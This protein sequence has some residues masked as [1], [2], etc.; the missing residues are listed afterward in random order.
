MKYIIKEIKDSL[1]SFDFWK[2]E[3][4]YKEDIKDVDIE[5]AQKYSKDLIEMW[6]D[7]NEEKL[8]NKE[9]LLDAI[10]VGDITVRDIVKDDDNSLTPYEEFLYKKYKEKYGNDDE[11]LEEKAEKLGTVISRIRVRHLHA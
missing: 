8:Y 10:Y 6:N 4:D 7:S 2:S 9:D 3:S 5:Y 1:P 11:H